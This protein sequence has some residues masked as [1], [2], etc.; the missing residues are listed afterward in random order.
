MCCGTV[1]PRRC[2]GSRARGV[3]I[4][5][6]SR[7]RKGAGRLWRIAGLSVLISA[8]LLFSSQLA[9]AQFS[10]QRK[11]VSTEAINESHQGDSVSLSSDG[12]T[13]I[14]GGASDNGGKGAA[15]V[16]TRRYKLI[17]T[18]HGL[19]VAWTWTQQKKL[20]GTGAIGYAY[21]G[22]SVSLSSDGNTAIVGGPGDDGG[23]GAAWVFTRSG[24]VWT[25][26]KKLVGTW[27]IGA[28]GQG[29]SVSLSSDGNT[30]IVGAYSDNNYSGAAWVF[31]RSGGVWTQQKKLVGTEAIITKED[32][33]YGSGQGHSVSLSSD[34]NTAIVGGILDNGF[35]GAAWVF[36]RSGGVW[37][38]QKKLVGMGAIN[39]GDSYQG[40]SVSL[41]SDGNTAIVGGPGDDGGKGAAWVYMRSGGVWTQ[42]KK[43]VGTEAIGDSWQGDSVSLSSDGNTAIV[44]GPSDGGEIGA[45]WVYVR[46]KYPEGPPWLK[47]VAVDPMALILEGKA[48][49]IWYEFKH[50]HE[51]K[52]AEIQRVLRSM[53]PEE[54]KATLNRA[55]DL[56]N[57]AKAEEKAAR[58]MPPEEQK[59][60]LN[61]AK[62]LANYAK[63][64][65][66]AFATM[67][68]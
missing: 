67:K 61:R 12:K 17:S 2:N 38:Q 63:V 21:Q 35:E 68:K 42:K 51:P 50:P 53:T 60:A 48:L 33:W 66:E 37:T 58:S 8:A 45:A 55:K 64:V 14:V 34:G 19:E 46:K 25:Q 59:A 3:S 44:G 9:L 26:Q 10:Q 4:E 5:P 23:K 7:K 29:G 27:A 18:G 32:G 20:V 62:T 49:D 16:F 11:L 47:Y 54:Q 65:E 43:L 36:T 13:A 40:H 41:S 28:S 24:G 56:A 39:G 1:Y 31:T 6:G 30:A 52:V 15:W 22:D 57:Y